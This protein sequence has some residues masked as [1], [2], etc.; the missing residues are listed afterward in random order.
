[1]RYLALAT[2]YDGTLASHDRVSNDVVCAL[3][4][5]RA[6][7]RRTILITGRRLDDLLAVCECAPL[8]DMLVAENGAVIYDPASREETRLANPPSKLLV[9]GLRARGVAPLDIGQVILATHEP[10]RRTVQDLVWELGLEA[11]V[12]G[13]RGAVMVL[14]AGINKGTGLE[15]ALRKL[16][17]SRHE[18]VGIGDAENDH[19]FLER[20]EAAVAVANALPALKESAALVTARENGNGVIELIDELVADDLQR[21]AGSLDQHLIMLGTRPDGSAVHLSP[22]GHNLLVAGPSGSGK[23]TVAAGIVERLIEKHY[24]V[25]IID[26]EG[27][28]GTLRDVVALGNQWRAPSVTEVLS[29][30]EDPN[31]NLSVNLLG[32]PLAD[33]P[34]FFGQLIPHLQAMRVRTGRPHWIVLDEAHHMLPDTWGHAHSTVPQRL[35][36]ILFVTVHPDHVAPAVLASIDIVIA[37]GA[38]PRETL[39]R[40]GRAASKRLEWPESLAC[41]QGGVVAWFAGRGEP[42]FT[43]QPLPGRIERI[44][45]KRKYAEGDLRWLS[46]YFRGPDCR[47]NLKAQNLSVFCQIAEGIDEQSWMY[48]LRR[49]DYSR[50]FRH[51]VRDGFLADEAERIE[52]REDIAPWQSRKIITELIHTRYTLPE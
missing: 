3:Q 44:R 13:N 39:A 25:C 34:T 12:I 51:S 41:E 31:V 32:I 23:S 45:H 7:G 35:G 50:W 11:Q 38:A 43:M 36:E 52:Q 48:H 10:H 27:D 40:F 19:S 49:G 21:L 6:S 20:C 14:P 18:V 15:H 16:G 2:D 37:I 1:M 9:Q 33:R 30:L 46:F 4:R 28:Y 5:V 47:H 24:Q 42:P 22:Y 29:I 26:P 8:F 17:L